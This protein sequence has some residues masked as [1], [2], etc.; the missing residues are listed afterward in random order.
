MLA[1]GITSI[2]LRAF[3][4]AVSISYSMEHGAP[5][6][7]DF[8]RF[9]TSHG[10]MPPYRT[11]AAGARCIARDLVMVGPSRLRDPTYRGNNPSGVGRDALQNVIVGLAPSASFT[12]RR[13]ISHYI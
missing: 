5:C 10:I 4:D 6:P 13:L 7:L 1:I 2:I 9:N 8:R 12:K 3:G 11:S